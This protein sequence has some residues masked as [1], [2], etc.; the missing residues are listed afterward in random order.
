MDETFHVFTDGSAIGNPGPGGW[1]AVLIRGGKSSEM[2][3]S[4]SWT[5]ISE[6]ELR[7]AIEALRSIPAGATVALHSDSELLIHGMRFRVFRWRWQGWRNSR[8]MALQHQQLWRELLRLNEL[9]NIRWLWIRG[10]SG[11]PI[12][13][14]ADALAYEEARTQSCSLRVAA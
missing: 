1:A 12:Q 10:H 3:G 11:H 9:L 14:R 5:T 2:S 7:A 13:S 8:G 4:S 6:M